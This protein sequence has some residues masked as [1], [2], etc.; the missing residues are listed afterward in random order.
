HGLTP[1]GTYFELSRADRLKQPAQHAPGHATLLDRC[2]L[3]ARIYRV[4]RTCSMR[5]AA[6]SNWS[7]TS[8]ISTSRPTYKIANDAGRSSAVR[9]G[10]A[11][12]DKPVKTSSWLSS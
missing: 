8:S 6:A 7:A 4:P 12:E 5:R 10:T 9:K 11:M 2:R 3:P 1:I